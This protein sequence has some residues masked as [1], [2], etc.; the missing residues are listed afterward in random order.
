MVAK[1]LLTDQEV[2]RAL[3]SLR[4]AGAIRRCAASSDALVR[5]V[6][7]EA[8][9]VPPSPPGA[10]RKPAK[11]RAICFNDFNAKLGGNPVTAPNGTTDR[12]QL[13]VG[14]LC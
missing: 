12:A 14:V 10:A 5:D 13:A 9:D 8:M 4:A 2:D 3:K 7:Y 11:A 6:R 1:G